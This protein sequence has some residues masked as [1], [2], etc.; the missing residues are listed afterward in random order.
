MGD[1][2]VKRKILIFVAVLGLILSGLFITGKTL[3]GFIFT[4]GFDISIYNQT[5]TKT[6][7]MK[8]TYMNAVKDI[9]VPIVEANSTIKLNVNPTENFGENSMVL[10]YFDNEGKRHEETIVG[11]F[12]KGYNG[13]SNVKIKSIDGVGKLTIEAK[14]EF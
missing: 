8:I 1:K 5:N 13:K 4:T 10:Y 6:S 2:Y 11:Y 14:E 7:G 9:E 12:E 3:L